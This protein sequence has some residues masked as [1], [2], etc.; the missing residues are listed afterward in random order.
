M[1]PRGIESN[2]PEPPRRL[3]IVLYGDP[4]ERGD[5]A[6]SQMVPARWARGLQIES[7][8]NTG[9]SHPQVLEG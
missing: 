9:E 5:L 2:N 6:C 3:A 7:V 4:C 8:A 1:L